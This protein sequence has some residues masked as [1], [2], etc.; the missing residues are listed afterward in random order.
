MKGQ[1]RRTTKK[2]WPFG[3]SKSKG[4]N[5]RFN[6]RVYINRKNI[7]LGS[8]DTAEAA[9]AA[10]TFV[11]NMAA[12]LGCTPEAEKVGTGQALTGGG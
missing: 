2:G 1:S 11:K 8:Y 10:A 3:V 7:Y 4:K 5:G 9:S 12:G 6:A